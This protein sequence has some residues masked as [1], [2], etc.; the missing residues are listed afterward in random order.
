MLLINREV[1]SIV[2]KSKL[3]ATDYVVN[4]YIGCA[5][6]C[7]Y[8]YAEFMMRFSDINKPWGDYIII[9]NVQKLINIKRLANKKILF[10][11]VT[12]P[13]QPINVKYNLTRELLR[14]FI[15]SECDIEILTKSKFLLNDMEIIKK[16]PKI[17]I[18]ISLSTTNDS[19]RKDIEPGASS[20][21][22]RLNMLR[23]L[24][25]NH[26]NTYLFISPIF[27]GISDVDILI[28]LV[29][30]YA[31]EIW[32]E[33]LNLR[34]NYKNKVLNLIRNKYSEYFPLFERIYKK[35]DNT[36]WNDEELRLR[37]KY[38]D[39][40]LSGRFKIFFYHSQLKK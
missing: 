17:K 33:N 2:T 22:D 19:F 13:Y 29:Y 4:P 18:G 14:Q 5:H 24:K 21:E 30:D 35:R 15:N 1:K 8:C 7:I 37:E 3:P 27:P 32:F 28:N 16:I 9:K 39:D 20:V 10:S 40:F 31:D 25:D 38:S 6:K 23:I 12:D 36:F 34:G 26:I 11:S